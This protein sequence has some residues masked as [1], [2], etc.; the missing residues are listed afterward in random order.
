[1][2]QQT[3]QQQIE[4]EEKQFPDGGVRKLTHTPG[5]VNRWISVKP[6]EDG[7]DGSGGTQASSGSAGSLTIEPE[8]PLQEINR[9]D[10]VEYNK[11]LTSDNPYLSITN[12]EEGLGI[13]LSK[14]YEYDSRV[15][16]FKEDQKLH[17]TPRE[18]ELN[19]I[20]DLHVLNSN[21]F[22]AIQMYKICVLIDMIQKH[23][24]SFDYDT[25]IL[26]GSNWKDFIDYLDKA[27]QNEQ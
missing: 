21:Y 10:W 7:G 20:E 9:E 12:Y 22:L 5:G 18:K 3:Q 4:G 11:Y 6:G 23:D 1:M 19:D 13:W 27:K 24:H 8:K 16:M 25:M 15:A 14:T 17:G 2:I 26:Q